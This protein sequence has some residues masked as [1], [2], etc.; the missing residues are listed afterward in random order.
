MVLTMI[1]PLLLIMVLPKLMSATDAD[2]QKEMQSQMNVLSN[3][4]NIPD[5]AEM[6]TNF[7]SG[8]TSKKA[9]KSKP[10]T[11]IKRK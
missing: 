10:S 2:T 1:V 7:F 8:G 4:P 3:R 9:V 6:F 11:S 5:A